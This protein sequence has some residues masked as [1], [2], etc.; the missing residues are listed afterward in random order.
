MKP[1]NGKVVWNSGHEFLASDV[2]EMVLTNP[3]GQRI[4]VAYYTGTCTANPCNDSIRHTG[5]N[6]ANYSFYLGLAE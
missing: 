4:R 3:A 5:Y 2:R 6:G 1:E